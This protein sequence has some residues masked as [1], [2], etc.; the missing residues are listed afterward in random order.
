MIKW[1]KRGLIIENPGN[2]FTHASHPSIVNIK[3][4]L[5]LLAFS[6]RKNSQGN[7]FLCHAE[8]KENKIKIISKP[9]LALEPSKPGYFDSEGLL[10]CCF[11][12]YK[13]VYYIY[14]TGWQNI[15]SGLWHCDTGRAIANPEKLTAK[16]EFDGPVM[17]RDKSNPIFAAAT[18][19]HVENQGIWKTWYNSGIS[20]EKRDSGWHPKYG[21]HY[22]TSK[23]G[24]D[25]NS[26]KG[27]V[28]PIKDIYE[29]SFGRPC[30]VK[31]DGKYR[32]WFAH[33]GT[34]DYSTYRI[35]YADSLDGIKW[36]RKDENS[37]ITISETGWD[38]ESIC[39]PY[40]FEHRGVRYMLYNGNNY[41]LTGFGYAIGKND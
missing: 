15:Q 26:H 1:E 24:V 5:F 4:D 30:V 33:R 41:G 12:K 25:W 40:L 31:W 8:V 2:N 22:A 35:G 11:V 17:G 14:Y 10:N 38:S 19:V 32:M 21:I 7:I 18:S 34:K 29:H 6:S 28:I 23:D 20:W 16:R 27:L 3:N 9:Q 36:N 13:N 37:G 39:Y